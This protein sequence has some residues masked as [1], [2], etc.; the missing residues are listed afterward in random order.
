MPNRFVNVTLIALTMTAILPAVMTAQKS[1]SI[2]VS[3]QVVSSVIPETRA[4]IDQQLSLLGQSNHIEMNSANRQVET[5]RGF[6]RVS[7]E[8]SESAHVATAD[9]AAHDA[10]SDNAAGARKVRITVAY[11]AN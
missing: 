2:R 4:A 10:C 8:T 7:T 11:T 9:Q 3:A 1:A 6:A 5:R